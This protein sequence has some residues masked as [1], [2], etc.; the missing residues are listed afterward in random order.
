[1]LCDDAFIRDL[2]RTWRGKDK[3]TD[4][5]SFAQDDSEILGDIVIALPTARYQAQAAG[6][7]QESELAL[8]AVHGLLHLLGYDD[9]TAD[10]AR[11]MQ[12]KTEAALKESGVALPTLGAHP[13][14]TLE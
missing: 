5:L 12:E 14:F 6:W 9:E 2:N 3:A 13:F 11:R 10:G 7:P 8:L 4:V 1:M